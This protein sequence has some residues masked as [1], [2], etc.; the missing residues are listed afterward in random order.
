MQIF[1][2]NIYSSISK[3]FFNSNRYFKSPVNFIKFVTFLIFMTF[4]FNAMALKEPPPDVSDASGASLEPGATTTS[5]IA[6]NIEFRIKNK[7]IKDVSLLEIK[8]KLKINSLEVVEPHENK[9][10]VFKGFYIKDLMNFSFGSEWQKNELAL[11][12]CADGYKD[13]ISVAKILN[14]N[15]LLAFEKVGDSKF[16]VQYPVENNRVIALGP[17]YLVW[18]NIKNKQLL[19]EGFY[20]WP[21]Q[22]VAIELTSFAEK[23]PNMIPKGKFD[24]HV[25][26]GFKGFQSYCMTCHKINGDGGDRGPELTHLQINYDQL[27]SWIDDPLKIKPLTTMP[28]LKNNIKNRKQVITDIVSYIQFMKNYKSKK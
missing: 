4:Q 28:A 15:P 11:F 2:L 22:V 1:L 5:V 10:V 23:F 18:D 7:K 3:F 20:G 12:I 14:E 13:P 26:N 25:M 24:D 19:S 9:K 17:F 27:P 16:S 21:Y 6:S 8:K